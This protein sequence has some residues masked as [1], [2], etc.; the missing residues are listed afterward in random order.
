MTVEELEIV[1]KANITDA[2]KGLAQIK[3]AIAETVKKTVEPI[4]QVSNQ[5]K[6]MAQAGTSN[7]KQVANQMNVLTNTTKQTTA[8][9]QLLINKINDMKADLSTIDTSKI[10]GKGDYERLSAEIEK[11]ENKLVSLQKTTEKTGNTTSNTFKKSLKSVRRFVLGIISVGSIYALVSRGMQSYLQTNDDAQKKYELT[12]NTIG[13]VLAPAMEKLL[14]I[15][16]Y[17]VI[18]VALLI[19]EFTGFNALANV[20]TKNISNAKD[21]TK[22]LNKELTAMDEITNINGG[23]ATGIDLTSD[24]SALADFQKKVAEVQ[25]LFEEWNIADLA[26]D[27]KGMADWLWKNRDA[28]IAVGI[29]LGAVFITAKIAGWLRSIALLLGVGGVGGVGAVGLIG[30]ATTLLWVV[31]IAAAGILLVVSVKNIAE[32][33]QGVKDLNS[34]IE[35]NNQLT[36]GQKDGAVLLTD[37]LKEFNTEGKL[38]SDQQQTYSDKLKKS[39][40]LMYDEIDALEGTKTWL[41]EITGKNKEVEESQQ[42]LTDSIGLYEEAITDLTGENYKVKIDTDIKTSKLKTFVG[43]LKTLFSSMIS[44]GLLGGSNLTSLPEFASGNVATSPTVGIFGEYSNASNNPEITTP[45]SIMRQTMT[46]VLSSILPQINGNNNGGT[47][48]LNLNGREFAK[49]IKSD[50]EYENNRVGSSTIIR[51]S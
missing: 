48:I 41:G 43:K 13:A 18:G 37:K 21:E 40:D 15:V 47:T 20:T 32:T 2:L 10:T 28:V 4:K 51:R 17:L 16:Q 9:Q 22:K 1:I 19:Q 6:V 34:A 35:S 29:A 45:Q 46:E 31:G 33:I 11:L 8:Q 23:N 12:S 5:T 36:K 49:A 39:I 7:I 50:L 27:L 30:L 25:K 26:S 14:D 24:Y 38:T 44:G 42:N 3:E